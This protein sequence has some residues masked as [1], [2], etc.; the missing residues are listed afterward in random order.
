MICFM[1]LGLTGLIVAWFNITLRSVTIIYMP[2]LVSVLTSGVIFAAL[3]IFWEVLSIST[4]CNTSIN[5]SFLHLSSKEPMSI[6]TLFQG[7]N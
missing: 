6:I 7:Y 4:G 5:V 2:M 1:V 3:L